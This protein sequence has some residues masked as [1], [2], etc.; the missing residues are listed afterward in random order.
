MIFN[1]I[2]SCLLIAIMIMPSRV[3]AQQKETLLTNAGFENGLAGWKSAGD[4]QVETQSPLAGKSSVQIGPGPG[5][6]RQRYDVPGLRILYVSAQVKTSAES[7]VGRLRVQCLDARHHMLLNLEQ[8]ADAKKAA[9]AGDE[10]AIYF[11]THAFTAYVIISIENGGGH[12]MVMADSVLLKD[13]DRDKQPHTPTF[14]FAQAIHPIWQGDTVY[15][16]TVLMLS[17]RGAAAKGRLLFQPSRILSVQDS[18]LTIEY[19]EGQDYTLDGR[20]IVRTANSRMAMMRDTDFPNTPYPWVSLAGKHVVVTYTHADR[21]TGPIPQFEGDQ[22]P[23]TM[24]RLDGK[25]PLTVVALGDSITLGINVSGFRGDPPYMPPYPDL[26]V[27]QLA[28]IYRNDRIKLYNVALGGMAAQWGRDNAESL[29]ASLRPD[30]VIIAFG[31]N[32]FWSVSPEEFRENIRA[33]MTTIR[34]RC[35]QV[36]FLL[37]ASMKFDPD[38][39]HEAVYVD[40]LAAYAQELRSLVGRGVRLFDMTTLSQALYTAK[41]QKDLATDP[42]HPDDFL[43]RWYAQGLVAML[44]RPGGVTAGTASTMGVSR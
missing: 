29:V 17:K 5:V 8:V 21:W 25:K 28:R 38:Y 9:G 16:E 1:K 4:V 14:D 20:E 12:G 3:Q 31:M 36:E 18:T 35:P 40:H 42:M 24:A 44:Q 43:A 41:S 15:H 30:L 10:P 27:Q 2:V 39:T 19:H 33:T 26:F 13:D 37:V 32:D 23:A 11:K 6:V 22:L 34:H 7:V